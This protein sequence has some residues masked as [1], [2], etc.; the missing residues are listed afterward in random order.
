MSLGVRSQD[1]PP[2]LSRRPRPLTF[3]PRAWYSGGMSSYR[4]GV[5]HRHVFHDRVPSFRCYGIP[6]YEDDHIPYG[7]AFIGDTVMIDKLLQ[8]S[9]PHLSLSRAFDHISLNGLEH[10]TLSTPRGYKENMAE[11]QA[12]DK[13]KLSPSQM[14]AYRTF[15]QYGVSVLNRADAVDQFNKLGFPIR[16]SYYNILNNEDTL[17]VF[18]EFRQFLNDTCYTDCPVS[19]Y[20]RFLDYKEKQNGTNPCNCEDEEPST[21]YRDLFDEVKKAYNTLSWAGYTLP[22]DT[23]VPSDWDAFY[24]LVN[25][26]KWLFYVEAS[27]GPANFDEDGLFKAMSTA[28]TDFVMETIGIIGEYE[29]KKLYNLPTWVCLTSDSLEKAITVAYKDYHIKYLPMWNHTRVFK[30]PS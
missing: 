20:E 23:V 2:K 30:R 18:N 19:D 3:E 10:L 21:P 7:V 8:H 25:L 17:H 24:T 22:E 9:N 6:V 12:T 15:V 1:V 4:Y 16:Y 14:N 26:Q 29:V 5:V 27:G 28:L 11:K 13:P